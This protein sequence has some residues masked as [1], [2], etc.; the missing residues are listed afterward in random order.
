VIGRLHAN[1]EA[2]LRDIRWKMKQYE[3][4]FSDLNDIQ[5]SA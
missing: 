1:H 4:S 3:L 2:L 5:F